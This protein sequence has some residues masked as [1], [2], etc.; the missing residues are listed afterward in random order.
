MAPLKENHHVVPQFVLKRFATTDLMSRE[1]RRT[2]RS[3][4]LIPVKH[5]TSVK[6]LYT[7]DG[8]QGQELE[9]FENLLSR[10][11]DMGARAIRVA[12]AEDG[13]PLSSKN[14][15]GLSNFVAAQYLRTPRTR[16]DFDSQMSAIR[17][18]IGSMNLSAVRSR[19]GSAY[20]SDEEF[21]RKWG[22]LLDYYQLRGSQPRNAQSRWFAAL[23]PGA[24]ES[25]FH[26]DWY[27]VRYEEP[28][29][30]LSDN[31]VIALGAEGR[32]RGVTDFLQ[33][34]RIT[35]PLDRRTALLI[36]KAESP[37]SR[38][39]DLVAPQPREFADQLNRM[40]AADCDNAVY[41][42]PEDRLFPSFLLLPS[43]RFPQS[44]AR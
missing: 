31:L 39:G 36:V 17:I 44:H 21:M 20:S 13:W 29:F 40:A 10:F 34:T 43:V 18:N 38:T 28:S 33:A 5:A 35:V 42:H 23:Q 30:V 22:E 1:H 6:H 3:S 12:L 41:E 2:T 11:E 7:T 27:L 32:I 8:E 19:I 16:G 14:R 24:A 4:K 26:R 37:D 15:S 9:I 25:L